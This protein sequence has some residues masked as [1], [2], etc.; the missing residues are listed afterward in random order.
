MS[1]LGPPVS[2]AFDPRALERPDRSLLTYYA[3][4]CAFSL[5]AYP[6]VF[7]VH[8]FKYETLRYRFD[9]DGISLSWGFLFRRETNLT[10]RR[11]QDIHVT[12]NIIQRWMNLATV[13][14]QTASGAASPEMRIEGV[15]EFDALRDFLYA[16]MRG[17]KSPT[18]P[19]PKPPHTSASPSQ[20]SDEALT[21]L[22][23]IRDSLAVVLRRQRDGDTP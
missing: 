20:D 13:S 4:V 19:T 17:A 6:I 14:I 8:F 18:P 21:L 22:R 9:D 23:D 7:L 5:I 11:I 16:Q 15:L 10:Y 12:R 3:I 1:T 2:P